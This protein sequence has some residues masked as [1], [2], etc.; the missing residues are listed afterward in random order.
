MR[1]DCRNFPLTLNKYGMVMV[2]GDDTL[3]SSCFLKVSSVTLS[4][5]VK[6][7]GIILCDTLGVSST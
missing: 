1:P 5:T 3:T 7:L 2:N 6:D 4:N